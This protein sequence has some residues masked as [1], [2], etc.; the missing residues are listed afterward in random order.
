MCDPL[1]EPIAIFRIVGYADHMTQTTTTDRDHLHRWIAA[2]EVVPGFC[3][4]LPYANLG[5]L[6]VDRV[7]RLEPGLVVLHGWFTEVGEIEGR[8]VASRQLPRS[9]VWLYHDLRDV[10][11]Y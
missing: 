9:P 2:D 8:Q 10:I 3:V 4:Q 7:E 1:H 11:A 5:G 6:E